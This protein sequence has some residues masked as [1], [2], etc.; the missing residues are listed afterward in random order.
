M[1]QSSMTGP[2]ADSAARETAAISSRMFP[3]Q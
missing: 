3:G 2:S 1:W